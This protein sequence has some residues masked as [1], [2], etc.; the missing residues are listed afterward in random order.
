MKKR[1][2]IAI[3]AF[4]ATLM[5]VIFIICGCKKGN[6][7]STQSTQNKQAKLSEE[8]D[9]AESESAAMDP[10]TPYV[11]EYVS[12]MPK[13]IPGETTEAAIKDAVTCSVK[14]AVDSEL[15]EQGAD[16][17]AVVDTQLTKSETGYTGDVVVT[18]MTPSAYVAS[19]RKANIT[20]EVG[21]GFFSWEIKE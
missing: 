12:N 19:Q 5:A 3:N 6:V 2:S 17:F 9:V 8:T 7:Q 13:E 20:V 15:E 1:K 10:L 4:F 16:M 14:L 21:R 18:Y 11:K